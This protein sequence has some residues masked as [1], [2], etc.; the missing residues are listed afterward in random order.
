MSV[1]TTVNNTFIAIVL[2][3]CGIE[4]YLLRYD[5]IGYVDPIAIVLTA[6]GIETHRKCVSINCCFATIAIVLTACGIE[7]IGTDTFPSIELMY[8]NSAYRLR[9]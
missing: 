1:I 8:C 9:Y 4:T 2:T 5:V 7:T 3:A 6:C